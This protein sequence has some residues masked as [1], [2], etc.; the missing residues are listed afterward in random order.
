MSA[1]HRLRL[2]LASASPRRARILESL[3]VPF[4]VVVPTV[5]E[6]LND[7][8][9]GAAAAVRLA[10]TKALSVAATTER[11]VLA[12]DTLVLIRGHILGKPRSRAHAAQML[13]RLS[14]RSHDVV[15]GVCLVSGG[16]VYAGHERTE[17]RFSRLDPRAIR[18]YVRTGEPLDK[19]GA[20]HIDG[21]GAWLV[22][23]ISGSPSNVEGLPVG[24]VLR[25][26]RR[27]GLALGPPASGMGRRA[28]KVGRR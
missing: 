16:N 13:G 8:E 24:L 21:I 14:G 11:P 26:C 4:T 28:V 23:G 10:R 27:A 1:V 15:T 6:A 3:G 18:W 17:V 19:A 25:L 5:D 12:A 9:E 7:E 22:A 2:I 20:Y